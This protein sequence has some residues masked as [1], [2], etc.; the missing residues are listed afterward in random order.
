[1]LNFEDTSAGSD[2]AAVEDD[3]VWATTPCIARLTCH[4]PSETQRGGRNLA[5]E[6]AA[7]YVVPNGTMAENSPRFQPWVNECETISSPGGTE[8]F[9]SKRS[10]AP[11]GA[12]SVRCT[13]IP[14]INRWA[15]LLSTVPVGLG[16]RT[17]F[18]ILIAMPGPRVMPLESLNFKTWSKQVKFCCVLQKEIRVSV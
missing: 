2:V 10:V 14:P 11:S 9:G 16:Q 12:W 17:S 4:S 18:Q 6:T 3:G 1:M 5:E 15:G 8:E 13:S 7:R